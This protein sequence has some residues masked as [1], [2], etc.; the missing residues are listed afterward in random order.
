MDVGIMNDKAQLRSIHIPG[1]VLTHVYAAAR[2]SSRASSTHLA[3][4]DLRFFYGIRR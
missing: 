4:S 1:K 2:H 3:T